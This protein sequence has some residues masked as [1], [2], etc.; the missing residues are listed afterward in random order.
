MDG[1]IAK[2]QNPKKRVGKMYV[3]TRTGL[4]ILK[5]LKKE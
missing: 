1:E 5:S 4:E 3:A 2:C